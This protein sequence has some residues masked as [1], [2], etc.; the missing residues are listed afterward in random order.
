MAAYVLIEEGLDTER[1]QNALPGD[2]LRTA[3]F[4]APDEI[5]SVHSLARSLLVKRR[6]P[7]ALVI[8][9][10]AGAPDITEER[11]RNT[12]EV[13]GMVAGDVPLKVLT[14]EDPEFRRDSPVV[15]ELAEFLTQMRAPSSAK[16][17]AAAAT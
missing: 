3:V 16:K 15:C 6:T 8:K 14:V 7:V 1:L 4:V 9:G 12:E 13:V 2:L 10:A 17:G 11:R 5:S